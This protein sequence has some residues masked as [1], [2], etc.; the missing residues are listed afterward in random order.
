MRCSYQANIKDNDKTSHII[1]FT[2]YISLGIKTGPSLFPLL[3]CK[4]SLRST[5][6]S[7]EDRVGIC[8]QS[9]L[10]VHP[11]LGGPGSPAWP[12]PAPGKVSPAAW[13]VT[14]PA[15]PSQSYWS[16]FLLPARLLQG[17]SHATDFLL[18][19]RQDTARMHMKARN[20]G[21]TSPQTQAQL[22]KK[23]LVTETRSIVGG[24]QL[25]S[26]GEAMFS[27]ALRELC[28]TQR[29]ALLAAA[30]HAVQH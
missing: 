14:S 1:V 24:S 19:S 13:P 5:I 9:H 16:S 7:P 27:L 30:V 18:P 8:G 4:T 25:P 12:H 21:Q 6:H 2:Q 17:K 15:V 20:S 28:R 29:R 23:M 11:A 22:P 10:A 26:R 3:T